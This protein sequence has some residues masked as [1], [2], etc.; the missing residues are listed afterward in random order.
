MFL[1]HTRVSTTHSGEGFHTLT[2]PASIVLCTVSRGKVSWVL[3]QI[4]GACHL[5]KGAHQSLAGRLAL[6]RCVWMCAVRMQVAL[7]A[8]LLPGAHHWVRMYS[9][10]AQAAGIE[11]GAG[12]ELGTCPN[13]EPG[14]CSGVCMTRFTVVRCIGPCTTRESMH[15]SFAPPLNYHPKILAPKLRHRLSRSGLSPGKSQL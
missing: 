6:P 7:D 11:V 9:K 5:P 2:R 13:T 4:R 10:D 15:A 1:T 8:A 3:L 14:S 12:I